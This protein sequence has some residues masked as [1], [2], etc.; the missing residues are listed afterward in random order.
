[1]LK[2][3][4]AHLSALNDETNKYLILKSPMGIDYTRLQQLLSQ[5]QW[6]AANEETAKKMLEV[7]G[8]SPSS[9]G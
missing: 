9:N 1:M 2:L 8:R 4:N 6:Q 3:N 5:Q 7:M